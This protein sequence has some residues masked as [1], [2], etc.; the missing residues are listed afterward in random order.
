LCRLD[1]RRLPGKPLAEVGGRPLL[2]YVLHRLQ[3][4][5]GLADAIVLATTD[6][7]VDDPLAAYAEANGLPVFR[8]SLDD[9]AGRMLACAEAY[10]FDRIFRINAD[11]PFVDPDLISQACDIAGKAEHDIVTN[12]CPRTFPYGVAVENLSVAAFARGYGSITD[13]ADLEHAT[14]YF[15]RHPDDF[16]LYNIRCPHGDLS[17]HRLTVDTAE[18]LE[19]FGR[20]VAGI[21]GDWVDATYQIAANT[22]M[23]STH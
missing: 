10:R 22:G 8:G 15:Y 14:Q 3:A 9:V 23:F 1:A 12:L 6:R 20:F 16:T 11:S 5:P 2:W 7:P 17:R 4:V 19:A 21:E 13:A 18:D